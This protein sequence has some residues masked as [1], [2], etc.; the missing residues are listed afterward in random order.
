MEH[1]D[2]RLPAP[3]QEP[4]EYNSTVQYCSAA[5]TIVGGGKNTL[6]PCEIQPLRA[7][8]GAAGYCGV[9]LVSRDMSHHNN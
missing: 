4:P 6:E 3:T 8:Q 5:V 2:G 9:I 7:C 1:L